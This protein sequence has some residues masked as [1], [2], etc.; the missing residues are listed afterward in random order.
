MNRYFTHKAV[1]PQVFHAPPAR[2]GVAS[3]RWTWFYSAVN[4]EFTDEEPPVAWPRL[5][6]GCAALGNLYAPVDDRDAAATL[7]AAAAGGTAYFDTAPYYGHGLSE[8]RLGAFLRRAPG[9]YL[10]STKVGRSL[11]DGET[12]GDTGFVG[13][14][15]ARPYFDYSRAAVEHQVAA[16]LTRLG[17]AVVDALF[18]HD[19]GERTHGAAHEAQMAIALEG[20]FP[21]LAA[22]KR[23]G[24]TRAVGLGVNEVAV[25]LDV[26]AATDLDLILLAGR[27]T[28]LDQQALDTL[29]PLC[30]ERG[31]G[32]VIGGPF[33][34][35]VLAG[36]AHYDYGAVPP[37]VADRVAALRSVCDAHGVPLAA[38]ALQFPLAH[39]AV[40]SVIPGARS[41][42]EVEQNLRHMAHPIPRALWDELKERGLLPADAPI[43]AAPLPG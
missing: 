21:A 19:L 37:A 18:V 30:V 20:A 33:N 34:S 40:A 26:L 38:A 11:A 36:D 12:P 31:V 13:A 5:G 22:L 4:H 9:P 32:V 8:Q 39:P 23:R 14:R 25:C 15:R 41:A 1:C 42:S 2:H 7:A 43:P 6:L 10:V 29:L 24:V 3:A 28:L 16:S 35:G 17:V 27:Y